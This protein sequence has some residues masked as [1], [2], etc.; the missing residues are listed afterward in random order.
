MY[1]SV[2]R[3]W[4]PGTSQFGAVVSTTTRWPTGARVFASGGTHA[5]VRGLGSRD[6]RVAFW[7]K[8]SPG[9][10][11]WLCQLV[12]TPE[13]DESSECPP[14]SRWGLCLKAGPALRLLA[15]GLLLAGH[16]LAIR[17]RQ[18]RRRLFLLAGEPGPPGHVWGWGG[19]G[20]RL[21]QHSG[22]PG[23]PGLCHRTSWTGASEVC[24]NMAPTA[25][26]CWSC[27]SG[28]PRSPRSCSHTRGT[29]AHGTPSP[30]RPSLR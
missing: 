25:V 2:L 6:A 19:P 21:C 29:Q 17:G 15:P 1:L 23:S 18:G 24:E 10:L 14:A 13:V 27:D 9:V 12:P 16:I 22:C 26:S 5:A 4:A 7:W 30:K 20:L 8:S 3:W 11:M 28:S